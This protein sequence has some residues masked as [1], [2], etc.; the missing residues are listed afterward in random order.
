MNEAAVEVNTTQSQ[1]PLSDDLRYSLWLTLQF[2]NLTVERKSKIERVEES[3]EKVRLS[4]RPYVNDNKTTLQRF[5][6]GAAVYL[7]FF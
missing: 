1:A 4:K 3:S 6:I 7:S 2:G 5:S